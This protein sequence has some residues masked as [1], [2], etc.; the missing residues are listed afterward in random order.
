MKMLV[1]KKREEKKWGRK[2][3][4]IVREGKPHN[5]DVL[6][7][8]TLFLPNFSQDID[9]LVWTDMHFASEPTW[10]ALTFSAHEVWP[11]ISQFSLLSNM[12]F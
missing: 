4:K 6:K 8:F 10:T 1:P 5:E 12:S 7:N 11:R 3:K 9:D 2:R